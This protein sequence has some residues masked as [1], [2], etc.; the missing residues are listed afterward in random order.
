MIMEVW[1][2]IAEYKG[3]YQVSSFGNVRSLDRKILSG[4]KE[5]FLNGKVLKK[6]LGTNGYL[7]VRLSKYS[8][9][10][11]YL[12]H[13]LVA[14]TF[15]NTNSVLLQVN[16]IDGDKGNNNVNNLEWCTPS[17]N[18]KHAFANGLSNQIGI[19]HNN[20]IF[21]NSD[22]KNIRSSSKTAKE[23]SKQYNCATT[24]IYAVKSRQNWNY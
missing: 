8:K 5:M 9:V 17:E 12:I 16:H 4:G 24:T 23:L 3:I 11:N 14:L 10:K 1:K 21:T 2:N 22:V 7:F 18:R 20:A 6:Q 13:R 19:N 15:M